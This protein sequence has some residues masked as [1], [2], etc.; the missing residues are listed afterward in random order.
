MPSDK[1]NLKTAWATD[2]ISSLINV[3]L[4][5][6]WARTV[7]LLEDMEGLETFFAHLAVKCCIVVQQ[8]KNTNFTLISLI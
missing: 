4:S 5:R 7:H 3:A 8:G 1:H 2:L 6:D